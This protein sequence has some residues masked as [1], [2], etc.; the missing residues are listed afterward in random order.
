MSP[1]L[2]TPYRL[3]RNLPSLLVVRTKTHF[4]SIEN[5]F[6][7]DCKLQLTLT[8]KAFAYLADIVIIF[9]C[10][11]CYLGSNCAKKTSDEIISW[12]DKNFPRI[13]GDQWSS[14]LRMSVWIYYLYFFFRCSTIELA[15]KITNS[16]KRLTKLANFW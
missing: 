8:Q 3:L 13:N 2:V 16:M 5:T 4:V 14:M 1:E 9:I 11:S 12:I 6:C 10:K 7:V 15:T